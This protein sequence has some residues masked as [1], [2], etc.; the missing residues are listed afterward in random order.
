MATRGLLHLNL[1]VSDLARSTRFY[2]EAFGLEVV[3]E[4]SEE[5]AVVDGRSVRIHQ[6]VLRT[7]GS[8]EL[9][10]LTQ[11]DGFP[12][13]RGGL[14]HLGFVVEEDEDV[15]AIVRDVGRLGGR[16]RS[17]GKREHGRLT[18]AFAYVEDP[19]GYPIE[20]STQRI[21]YGR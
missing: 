7:P 4:P 13:G 6:V 10:A 11:A 14:N 17:S 1:N 8:R 5:A 20:V 2:R 21:L 19:D 3:A 18:E 16:V 12:V 9:F 15:D